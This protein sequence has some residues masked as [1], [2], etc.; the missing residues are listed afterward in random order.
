MIGEDGERFL[1]ILP[2]KLKKRDLKFE[3]CQLV[4]VKTK[5]SPSQPSQKIK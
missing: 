5:K 1:E 2:Q 4:A 3:T